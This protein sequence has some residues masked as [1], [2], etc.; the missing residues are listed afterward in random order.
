MLAILK[1][2]IVVVLVLLDSTLNSIPVYSYPVKLTGEW[3]M[4]R[5]FTF[6]FYDLSK[7]SDAT[8]NFVDVLRQICAVTPESE[9]EKQLTTDYTIR[10]ERLENDG[11]DAVVGEMVRCQNNN[12]PSQIKDGNRENLDVDELGH[13]IVFRYNGKVGVLGVQYD[14][15]IISPGRILEYVSAFNAAAV[16]SIDPKIDKSA[17]Q[18]FANGE[19]RNL[20]VRIAHPTEM[21]DL[22]GVH[23]DSGSGLRAMGEAYS[24]PHIKFEISMGHY[25]GSLQNAVSLAKSLLGMSGGARVEGMRGKV[26]SNDELEELDLLEHRVVT[27]EDLE[28]HRKDFEVN[29]KV[30]R[31]FLCKDMKSRFG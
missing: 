7:T 4:E 22:D 18:K 11:A 1:S 6:R 21:D 25:K 14:H 30:K 3:K 8:P 20:A 12:L 10:L 28:I 26:I 27:K 17:W 9:R 2:L 24:A 15:R 23:Q 16:Y 31:D 19:T 29:W 5:K 13:S